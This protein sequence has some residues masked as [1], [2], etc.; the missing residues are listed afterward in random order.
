MFVNGHVGE[1]LIV[2]HSKL[3]WAT[4]SIATGTFSTVPSVLLLFF[5]T[6]TLRVPMGYAVIAVFVPKAM[7]L[8]VDPAVGRLSDHLRPRFGRRPFLLLGALLSGLSLMT[9]FSIPRLEAPLATAALVGLA[10]FG[11]VVA[12]AMFSVPY[13]SMPP[14]IEPDPVART[15]LIGFR[16]MLVAFGI[17]A[18][19][20]GGP[21]LVEVGGGG[22]GGYRF[23]GTLLGLLVMATML[24]AALAR[25]E[26]VGVAT[27][28][29]STARKVPQGFLALL[30]FYG[31]AQ[32]AVACGSAAL[33]YYAVGLEG[34][35]EARLGMLL[36]VM[37]GLGA[38][39]ATLWG[40]TAIGGRR[41]PLAAA[42]TLGVFGYALAAVAAGRVGGFGDMALIV[43]LAALGMS[44]TGVQVLTFVGLAALTT[45]DAAGDQAGRLTGYL[46]ALEKLALAAGPVVA[47]G[48]MLA[49]GVNAGSIG[50]DDRPAITL[51]MAII[52]A[53]LLITAALFTFLSGENRP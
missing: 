1:S 21:I 42:L 51:V 15:H 2:T 44:A 30:A 17:I 23:M 11:A 35:S 8:I 7:S 40:R 28:A 25:V 6:Q 18:G 49:L 26:D 52:P 13:I 27:G 33:P 16:M 32:V 12:F 53:L 47:G 39:S 10:Y 48:A 38:I 37:L 29:T 36:L 34:M 19:G 41:R 9:L 5:L 22:A 14:A 45:D 3:Q 4:G 43:A 31:L 24:I 20:A 50:A 46:T